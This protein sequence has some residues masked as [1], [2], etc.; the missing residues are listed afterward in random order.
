MILL[1]T[2]EAVQG[3]DLLSITDLSSEDIHVLFS[4]AIDMKREKNLSIL[5]DKTLALV[6]EKPS[7]RI[8]FISLRLKLV[9]GNVNRRGT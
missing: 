6:F 1:F 8:P 9:W 5:E 7:L 3:K 2:E 4:D